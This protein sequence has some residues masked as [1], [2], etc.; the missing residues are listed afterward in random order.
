MPQVRS[1][2]DG[3]RQPSDCDDAA[4]LRNLG[5]KAPAGLDLGSNG[6][7][8]GGL[9]PRMRR[10]DVPAKR[11]FLELELF[12]DA[13]NDR[14]RR[15]GRSCAGELPFRRERDSADPGAAIAGR[16]ADE[17]V[18]DVLACRQIGLETTP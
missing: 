13:A 2:C 3:L 16:L 8:V 18:T 4:A 12:E 6:P 14:C 5:Q 9:G 7:A 11:L 10:H 1:A 15:F 17:E